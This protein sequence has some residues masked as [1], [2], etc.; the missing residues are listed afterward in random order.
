[1]SG[2]HPINDFVIMA[3]GFE[4]LEKTIKKYSRKKT[5]KVANLPILPYILG[6]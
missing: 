1:M 6:Y 5:R 3:T 4:N 2:Y